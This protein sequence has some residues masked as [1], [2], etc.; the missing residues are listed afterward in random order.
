ML[1]EWNAPNE[2]DWSGEQL[3]SAGL[4][5]EQ[6]WADVWRWQVSEGIAN[7]FDIQCVRPGWCKCF[8]QHRTDAIYVGTRHEMA[9]VFEV[10][11]PVVHWDCLEWNNNTVDMNATNATAWDLCLDRF[12][13]DGYGPNGLSPLEFAHSADWN[14]NTIDLNATNET[15]WELCLAEFLN[16]TDVNGTFNSSN[17][18]VT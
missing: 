4:G 5:C 15:A 12:V 18:T 17:T 3:R 1:D 7:I 13:D 2:C 10:V 14:N 11:S 6:T 9:F 16:L 8:R